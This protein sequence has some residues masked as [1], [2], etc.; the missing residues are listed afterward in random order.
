MRGPRIR[1][2]VWWIMAAVAAFA[3]TLGCLRRPYPVGTTLLPADAE[4]PVRRY[5][6]VQHWSDGRVQ[7]IGARSPDGHL[8]TLKADEPWSKAR[9]R[10]GPFLRVNWSDGSASYYLCG[11]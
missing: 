10:Y 6:I 11:R 8:Q 2:R 7:Y 9:R 5:E 3:L 4:S 1:L